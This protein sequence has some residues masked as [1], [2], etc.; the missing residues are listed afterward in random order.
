MTEPTEQQLFD[1]LCAANRTQRIGKVI[2]CMNPVDHASFDAVG[3]LQVQG[4]W[5]L[6]HLADGERAVFS[7]TAKDALG[8]LQ[9][10]REGT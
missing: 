6:W 5:E 9:W 10:T 2:L 8:R 3:P 7:T 4:P 1:A